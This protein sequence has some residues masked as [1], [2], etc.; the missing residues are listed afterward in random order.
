M[1]NRTKWFKHKNKNVSTKFKAK[2]HEKGELELHWIMF[3]G[4]KI[5]NS[6]IKKVYFKHSGRKRVNDF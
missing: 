1:N 4:K 3:W 5:L 6:M 2:I